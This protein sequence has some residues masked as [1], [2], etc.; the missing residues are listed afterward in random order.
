[1][2]AFIFRLAVP[3][4]RRKFL[5][6]GTVCPVFGNKEEA[7]RSAQDFRFRV[8]K[9]FL[10]PSVPTQNSVFWVEEDK[11]VIRR[12]LD[13]RPEQL[14]FPEPAVHAVSRSAQAGLPSH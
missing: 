9:R 5:L 12:V 11:S 2:P 1:M 6:N 8:P 7:S 10:G 3:L 13:G 14:L 4:G